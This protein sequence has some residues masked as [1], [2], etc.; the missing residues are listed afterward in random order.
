M[1]FARTDRACT[2]HRHKHVTG[3]VNCFDQRLPLIGLVFELR[4]QAVDINIQGIFLYICC[5]PA[6]FDQL[7]ASGNQ[8]RTPD[9]SL[10]QFKLLPCECNFFAKTDS[11][12]AGSIDGYPSRARCPWLHRGNATSNDA[13]P[14]PTHL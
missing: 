14:R 11:D 5:T 13:D 9:E 10:E 3:S 4:A 6:R 1:S 8:T 2:L 12:A 7:F